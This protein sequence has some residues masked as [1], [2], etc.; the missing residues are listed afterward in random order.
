MQE[1]KVEIDLLHPTTAYI[2][3][4]NVKQIALE[5]NVNDETM[6]ISQ[7]GSTPSV[8]KCYTLPPRITGTNIHFKG[9]SIITE[10]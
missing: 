9:S 10:P 6:E 3:S 2:F 5:L 1:L 8:K 4:V 7:I